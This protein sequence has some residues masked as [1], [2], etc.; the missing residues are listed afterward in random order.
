M[1]TVHVIGRQ[2]RKAFI[3]VPQKELC[4][5]GQ[6]L[7]DGATTLSNDCIVNDRY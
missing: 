4:C 2:Y 6:R 3:S 7:P 5:G 1:R